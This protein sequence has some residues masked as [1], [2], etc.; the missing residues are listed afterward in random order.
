METIVGVLEKPLRVLMTFYL[1]PVL[2]AVQGMVML[3]AD[4]R[5]ASL[6]LQLIVF[7]VLSAAMVGVIRDWMRPAWLVNNKDVISK[8][9]AAVIVGLWL[10]WC[11][12]NAWTTAAAQGPLP[13]PCDAYCRSLNVTE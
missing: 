10:V 4:L 6:L 12:W 3:F 5:E 13:H 1:E 7:V 8:G 11:Y 9:F 2:M